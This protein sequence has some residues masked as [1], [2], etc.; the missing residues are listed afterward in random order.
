MMNEQAFPSGHFVENM[1]HLTGFDSIRLS[2]I[3]KD[4]WLFIGLTGV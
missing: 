3:L 1:V 4:N 2:G